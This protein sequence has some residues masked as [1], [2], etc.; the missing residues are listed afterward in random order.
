MSGFVGQ[1]VVQLGVGDL[2]G[3]VFRDQEQGCQALL[4]VDEFPALTIAL[5]HD[6][7]LKVVVG[8]LSPAG[9]AL[10]GLDV[11]QKLAHFL[12]SPP[13]AA[14]VRGDE[15]LALDERLVVVALHHEAGLNRRLRS[16]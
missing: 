4:A 9:F 2:R 8:G 11:L 3:D 16:N 10:V 6:N 5:Q 1:Q 15:E 14:L 12:A 13:V 7:R